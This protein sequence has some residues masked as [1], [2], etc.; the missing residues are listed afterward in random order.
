MAKPTLLIVDD[1]P[2]LGEICQIFL[3]EMGGFSCETVTSGAE[4]LERVATSPYD[5]IVSDYQMPG[6]NGIEL[7]KEIRG[8]GMDLP[9]IIFTG[10]GR[11]AVVIE[12]LNSGADFY[13]QKGGDPEALFIELA[14][15]IRQAVQR[16]RTEE[17]LVRTRFSIEHSPEEYYWIDCDGFLLDVNEQSCS[18]LGYTREELPR[19]RVMDVDALYGEDEWR[20]LWQRL[21]EERHLRIESAHRKK[22]GTVYPVEVSL[23]HHRMGDKEFMCAFA[24]DISGKKKA[25]EAA[26]LSDVMNQ[27][28]FQTSGEATAVFNEDTIIVMANK[29]FERLSGYPA[30]ELVGKRSWTEFVVEEDL[31]RLLEYHRLRRVPG[32]SAPRCY[33]FRVVDRY[34]TVRSYSAV[35]DMIPGTALRIASYLDITERK[36]A[37][38]AI[39][40]SEENLRFF[41][42]ALP[43]PALLLSA[44]GI[45]LAA[46]DAMIETFVCGHGATAGLPLG[47]LFPEAF[48]VLKLPLERAIRENR[49]VDEECSVK[50]RCINVKI[51]PVTDADGD[52]QSLAVYGM[53]VTDQKNTR[54]ALK[55][56]NKKLNL[57]SGITRHDMLNQITVALGSL[58]LALRRNPDEEVRARIEHAHTAVMN[59][60]RSLEFAKDYQ[61]MGMKAPAWQRL[62]AVVMEAAA[63]VP[64]EGVLLDVQTATVE[65]FADPMLERV[66]ANLLDNAVRHGEG[67]TAIR[68]SC[69]EQDD[70]SGAIVVEDNGIGVP[71][72][73]KEWI[74]ESGY[75]R[76]TGHGL[77]LVREILDITGISIV[78][79]G[80][81][82]KGARF[83]IAAPPGGYRPASECP[84]VA[85][86]IAPQT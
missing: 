11:E 10:K 23:A 17:A 5:A 13:L 19:L 74:F 18:S 27:A 80:E 55:K 51:C 84:G 77:F 58:S 7:L 53:D 78:E 43:E 68:I 39:R 40:K 41:M 72:A 16:K 12:A 76:H 82:G 50:G 3:E 31:E 70:G 24:H 60:Q 9:F 36:K 48:T 44:N 45:V 6:M 30:C 28:I 37:E 79:T 38:E 69:H 62:D 2:S 4:A 20:A 66:F 26:R 8:G 34:G 85:P 25:Q 22:D 29:E 47:D 42:N 52:V 81:E 14:S 21:K 57:L 54:D 32:G 63:S 15:K 67:V 64:L 1:E 86:P 59:I 71:E 65:V 83:V 61:D 35:V 56:A 46:N 73:L 75:G 49:F 33:E